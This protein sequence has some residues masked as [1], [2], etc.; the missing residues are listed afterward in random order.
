MQHQ[1]TLVQLYEAYNTLKTFK[2]SS[3]I[4]CSLED[5]E[6]FNSYSDCG[7]FLD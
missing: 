7:E 3:F 2:I 6:R 4:A 5:S 1:L